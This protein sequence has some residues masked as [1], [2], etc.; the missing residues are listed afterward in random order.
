MEEQ[1][2]VPVFGGA[3][4]LLFAGFPS[5]SDPPDAGLLYL[6]KLYNLGW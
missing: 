3:S 4:L 6:E 2:S 5:L 1:Q